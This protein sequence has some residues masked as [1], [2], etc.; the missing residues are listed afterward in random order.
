MYDYMKGFKWVEHLFFTLSKVV[1]YVWIPIQKHR[2]YFK[3]SE[4]SVLNVLD[5]A[6]YSK[7]LNNCHSSGIIQTKYNISMNQL[8]TVFVKDA[9]ISQIIQNYQ[10]FSV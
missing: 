1:L 7:Q 9:N 8:F 4:Q 2:N 6:L 5:L 3:H 10:I